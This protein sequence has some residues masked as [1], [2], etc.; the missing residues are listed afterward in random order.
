MWV[1][2]LLSLNG[3][4]R[5]LFVLLLRLVM[6][7]GMLLCVVMMI[8]GRFLLWWCSVVSIDK[9]LWF[10]SLRLSSSNLQLVVCSVSD[11]VLL[12]FIQLIVKFFCLRFCLSLL[13]ISGLFLMSSMCMNLCFFKWGVVVFGIFMISVCVLD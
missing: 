10:G 3:L 4:M 7:F 5:Q 9:L 8:V 12:F 1:S 11:V 6:W 2:S 13:L